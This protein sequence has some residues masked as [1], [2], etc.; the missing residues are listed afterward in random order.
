MKELFSLIHCLRSR[1]IKQCVFIVACFLVFLPALLAQ[2]DS[3]EY[4]TKAWEALGKRNFEEVAQ[5][6]ARCAQEFGPQ[7]DLLAQ[8]M[9]KIPEQEESKYKVLNDVAVCY[10]V[11][12]ESLMR[13]GKIEEAKEV[14]RTLIG[15]YPYASG[16]DPRGWFWSV[17][18]KAE[19]TLTKLEKGVIEEDNIEKNIVITQI[20]LADPGASLPIEY[21][22]FG[23]FK[24]VGTKDYEFMVTD[25]EGLVKAA[26]EGVYPNSTSVR[27][28]PE[29]VRMKNNK[30]LQAKH[31]DILNGR[32]LKKAFYIWNICG[33]PAGIKQFYIGDLLER[34]GLIEQAV[35]AYYACLVFFP[36]TYGWTYWH[37]PWY[38]AEAALARIEYLLSTFPHLGLRLEGASV[39]IVNGF[40][41]DVSN[42][43]FVIN[44]GK[45]VRSESLNSDIRKKL[46]AVQKSVGTTVRLVQYES[47]DWQLFVHDKPFIVKGITYAPTRVGESP[48]EGTLANWTEQDT[49]KN[50]LIDGPFDTWV[51]KDYNGKQDPGE[52]I[53][54]D[55]KLLKDMGVNALRVYHQPA[56]PN[57]KL[58]KTL[59]ENYGIMVIMADFLG[60]YAIGSGASWSEG[61]NYSDLKHQENMLSSVRKMVLEY[62]DEP[63]ILFWLLGNENVYGVACNANKDP[64]S[65]FKFANKAAQLIK[66]LDPTRPVAIASGDVLYLDI[67]GKH[68]PDI[69]IFGTNAYRGKYGFGFIWDQVKEF[70]NKPCLI[71]EYGAPAYGEGYSAQEAE[72]FQAEYHRANWA[73]IMRNSCCQGAGNALG[74]IVFEWLDE[75]WKAYEPAYHDRKGLFTGPF[76]D[77][78]MHEEWLGLVSQGDGKNSP[79]LRKLRKAYFTY[80]NIWK[81]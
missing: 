19:I 45:I 17:K 68:A 74:G 36:R 55:F 69:D 10:F 41:Y 9:T 40:D 80:Q 11:Q 25:M 12:G 77:G 18:E 59:Y 63:Y 43:V 32:D 56:E 26:G 33:E 23:Q 53:Q 22:K 44:P 35:K 21:E 30:E 48:D 47:G 16:W 2:S 70:A 79:F 37:T 4:L 28:D 66:E 67:F 3:S 65:F 64:E 49:N 15:K 13:Q 72:D 76:L 60:K 24:G 39:K 20:T 75:W 73:H 54:G 42:D 5:L 57:K 58:F 51:D 27:Y 14:F 71:T 6:T 31:W 61:T 38:I 78:F 34:S 46:G 81:N 52:E 50:G 1:M 8:G 7:A 29:F 62:K